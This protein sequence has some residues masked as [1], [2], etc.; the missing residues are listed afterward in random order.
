MQPCVIQRLSRF[1]HLAKLQPRLGAADAPR[2][3][4]GALRSSPARDKSVSWNS[5]RHSSGIVD[6]NDKSS[7]IDAIFLRLARSSGGASDNMTWRA[8]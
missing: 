7:Y 4:G 2:G 5:A 1:T 6:V 3:E 8:T